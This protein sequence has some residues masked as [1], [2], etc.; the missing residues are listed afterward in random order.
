MADLLT[1]HVL[2]FQ[3]IILV[4]NLTIQIMSKRFKHNES[5]GIIARMLSFLKQLLEH[6]VHISHVE[7]PCQGEAS[8]CPIIAAQQWMYIAE[9]ALAGS[10][11]AQMPDKE[12]RG[13]R[14]RFFYKL[15]ITELFLGESLERCMHIGEYLRYGT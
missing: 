9:P 7:I 11:V 2:F 1:V 6:F 3:M 8:R 14:N 12:F 13:K 10:A 5:V 4:L 15:H